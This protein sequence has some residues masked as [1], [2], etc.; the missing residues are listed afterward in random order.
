MDTPILLPHERLDEVNH[1]IRLIQNTQGLTFGTDALLL[2]AF[3]PRTPV[4]KATELGGGTGI[5]SLLALKTKR[6]SHIDCIE[7]QA[8]FAKLIARNAALNGLDDR[9]T[10]HAADLRDYTA[11][12]ERCGKMDV[13]FANPPY[14]VSSGKENRAPE[15]QAARHEVFG[16]IADFVT[17][18]ARLLRYGGRFYCVYRPDRLI[19][20]LA[21][22]REN[23]LEPKRMTFVHADNATPPSMVLVEALAGGKSSL[24][25]TPPFFVYRSAGARI[26]SEDMQTVLDSGHFPATYE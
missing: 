24:R 26:Y 2:A 12:G 9:L 20:L 21:A 19:D 13:V 6:I 15:K 23:K 14:M 7:V 17:A 5:I 1:G 18:A 10:S 3:L 22:L 16:G 11:V 25:V 8:P 4:E